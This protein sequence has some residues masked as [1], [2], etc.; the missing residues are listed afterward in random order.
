MGIAISSFRSR[1]PRLEIETR[2]GYFAKEGQCRERLLQEGIAVCMHVHSPMLTLALIR[3]PPTN[4]CINGLVLV[5]DGA[6]LVVVIC[7][8][9][10]EKSWVPISFPHT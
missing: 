9:H 10:K 7:Y 6:V 5:P 3:A 8:R 2:R 1:M 4:W